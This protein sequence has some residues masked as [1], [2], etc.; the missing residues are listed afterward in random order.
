MHC[1]DVCT[2]SCGCLALSLALHLRVITL[3][4]RAA[5]LHCRGRLRT[6]TKPGFYGASRCKQGAKVVCLIQDTRSAEDVENQEAAL[7]LGRSRRASFEVG[8]TQP[9]KIAAALE[10][11]C[12]TRRGRNEAPTGRERR[13]QHGDSQCALDSSWD[14]GLRAEPGD[15]IFGGNLGL[16]NVGQRRQSFVEKGTQV[17]RRD[18]APGKRLCRER[19]G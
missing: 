8:R 18:R 12:C 14:W 6:P 10:R 11:R 1:V 15:G 17:T 19:T 16:L 2:A 13:P 7:Q 4:L 9:I 3:H 5:L